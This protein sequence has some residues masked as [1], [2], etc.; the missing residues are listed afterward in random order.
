MLRDSWAPPAAGAAV[1][2]CIEPIGGQQSTSQEG[3]NTTR[4]ENPRMTTPHEEVF[5]LREG[6]AAP[7]FDLPAHPGGRVALA[8]YRGKKNVILAFYPKDDTPGC[9]REM[10]N[11]STDSRRFTEADTVVLGISRDNVTSHGAFAAKYGLDVVLLADTDGA[12][13]TAYGA[14]YGGRAMP[15]RILFVID[16]EGIIRHVYRGM[17]ENGV[18]LSVLRKLG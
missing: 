5:V 1:F 6:D 11:F 8:D 9:T 2:D 17:P 16:K 13:G 4:E 7:A 12:V 18:L 3:D 10:C 15:D 14:V